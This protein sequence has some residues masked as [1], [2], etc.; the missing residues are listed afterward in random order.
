ME[1]YPVEMHF[2]TEICTFVPCCHGN[3][4]NFGFFSLGMYFIGFIDPENVY[5]DTNITIIAL[6]EAKIIHIV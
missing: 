1:S 3:E 5:F 2:L 6:T 4:K